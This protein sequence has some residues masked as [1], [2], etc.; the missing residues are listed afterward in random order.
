MI[1]WPLIFKLVRW[2]TT[3]TKQTR[4]RVCTPRGSAKLTKLRR[5]TAYWTR[6]RKRLTRLP[7]AKEIKLSKLTKQEIREERIL[8]L[9]P[10][11]SFESVDQFGNEIDL[12]MFDFDEHEVR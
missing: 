7:M 11:G 9:A 1:M 12:S 4:L 5:E 8:A 10:T 3:P 6:K 2:L